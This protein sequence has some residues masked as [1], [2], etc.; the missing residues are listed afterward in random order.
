MSVTHV[1]FCLEFELLM[2]KTCWF[3]L[4]L[5]NRRSLAHNVI[6]TSATHTRIVHNLK[7][8]DWQ[9]Q[10]SS[11]HSRVCMI[12]HIDF[13]KLNHTLIEKWMSLFFPFSSTGPVWFLNMKS[14]LILAFNKATPYSRNCK[15]IKPQLFEIIYMTCR[16]HWFG[17]I[18]KDSTKDDIQHCRMA[19][20]CTWRAVTA[21]AGS[22]SWPWWPLASA[23]A[24]SVSSDRP[25]DCWLPVRSSQQ[26]PG[27]AAAHVP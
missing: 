5:K 20:D 22:Q 24:R 13:K 8:R 21:T 2:I 16:R 26:G 12:S 9:T 3:T 15:K 27:L 11:A 1:L 10:N 23:L 7:D 25:S 19:T 6:R 18:I 17:Q 14:P 4:L